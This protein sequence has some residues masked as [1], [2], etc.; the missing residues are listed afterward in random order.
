MVLV[1][2]NTSMRQ[3]QSLDIIKLQNRTAET[4]RRK[5]TVAGNS[6]LTTLFI[7][8]MDVGASIEVKYYDDVSSQSENLLASHGVLT[9]QSDY[10]SRLIVTEIHNSFVVEAT[11]TG[12][13]VEFMVFTTIVDNFPLDLKG[14]LDGSDANLANDTGVPIITYDPSDG[15][16]Y[17]LQSNGG[18]LLLDIAGSST[19]GDDGEV[20]LNATTWTAIPVSAA[21]G[22]Q[23]ISLQN[24]SDSKMKFSFNQPDGFVGYE[25]L[26]GNTV[27]YDITEDIIVYGKS[28]S[29]TSKKVFY[30]VIG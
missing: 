6:I 8:S 10:H 28:E 22:Q 1:A 18:K 19:L 23:S 14:K 9:G 15:K 24:Q 17:L 21:N 3:Y 27:V 4:Y 16:F 11:V 26:P 13:A 7:K 25:V 2:Q 20:D 12:G 5:I 30:Q 29:G